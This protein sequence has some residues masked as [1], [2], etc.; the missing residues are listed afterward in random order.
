MIDPITVGIAAAG[1]VGVDLGYAMWRRR[2]KSDG[3]SRKSDGKMPATPLAAYAESF[4]AELER[5]NLRHAMVAEQ[6][7][8]QQEALQRINAAQ[9]AAQGVA[10]AVER[11]RAASTQLVRELKTYVGTLERRVSQQRAECDH[12]RAQ[13]QAPQVSTL[14][15]VIIGGHHVGSG[16]PVPAKVA[17]AGESVDSVWGNR[18]QAQG[19][20]AQVGGYVRTYV[21]GYVLVNFWKGGS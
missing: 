20:A 16:A 4:K 6:Q 13:L 11:E 3:N 1:L 9:S 18:E 14:H 17:T 10:S 7:A 12:L 21:S 19:R 8:K 15:A 5:S 2:P